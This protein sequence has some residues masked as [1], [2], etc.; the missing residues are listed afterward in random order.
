MQQQSYKRQEALVYAVL[1]LV[2]LLAP[3]V[4][5]QFHYAQTQATA[6]PWGELFAVWKQLG[7]FFVAFLLH[8]FLLAPLIV[9]RQRRLLYFSSIAVLV[10]CFA[11]VQCMDRPQMGPHDN[12]RG[13]HLRHHRHHMIGDQCAPFAHD[14]FAAEGLEDM[15]HESPMR[16]AGNTPRRLEEKPDRMGRPMPMEQHDIVAVIILV[17]MLGMN[18]GVKLYFKQRN[19]QQ[20][21]Q[22]LEK[23]NLEQQLA[24]LRYQINPHFLM[25]TLNNIHALVDIEPE[26]AKESI[27]ELSK[28]LRFALYEGARQRVPL[29]RDVAFLQSYIN[30]MRLRY[31]DKVRIGINFP[32]SLPDC[33]IPPMMFI[34][35]VENA[36]KHGVSYRQESFIDI[37]LVLRSHRLYFACTNS[38]AAQNA[39][40]QG[41]VGLQNV[42]RRLDLIYGRDY[43]LV[44][45]DETSVYNIELEI[46]L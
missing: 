31:S 16:H 46:P 18:V 19:D 39:K 44:I 14:D 41:G 1:W 17:L 8:N 28:I 32:E 24:Y 13:V 27:V 43:K 22:Q 3:V 11:V 4:S 7:F 37:S 5:I 36:F 25:N 34:T 2:L 33:E 9:Y 40:E 12:H 21:L 30:L 10:G 6:Y 23:E 15:D 38:K 29:G 26:Q 45:K 42:K 35:F 20:R